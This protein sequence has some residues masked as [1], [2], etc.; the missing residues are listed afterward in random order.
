MNNRELAD[1]YFSQQD[2]DS[3]LAAYRAGMDAGERLYR[4]GLST[5]SKATEVAENAHLY[6]HAAFAAARLG[7]AAEALLILER[8]KTRLLTEA[9]RLRVPRPKDVP[10]EV[11]TAF[12]Q[13][14]A[15]VRVVQSRD[16]AMPGEGRDPVQAYATR[17]QNAQSASAALDAAVERVRAHAPNFLRAIDWPTLQA[18]LPDEHTVLL[19]FCMTDQR[20][21]GFVL[22]HASGEPVRVVDVPN[23]TQADLNSLL[24]EEDTDGN[25]NGGWLWDY[26]SPDRSRWHR[27]AEYVLAQVGQRLVAPVVAALPTGI[28][29]LILLPAGGLFLLPL[30]AVSL[31]NGDSDRLCDRYQISYAPSA[32]V[33]ADSRTKAMRASGQALY[34]VINPEVDP[35]LVFTPVEGT[36]I[37]GLFTNLQVHEG[38]AGTKQAVVAGLNGKAFLHFSCH[39]SYNWIDPLESGLALA[40]GRLT[41]AEL[42]SGTVDLSAARLVTLSACETGIIDVLE[43]RAEEYVGLP[44][45]FMLAGVPCVVSSLWS[46]PDIS[47]ALLMGR[48]YRNH[49]KGGMNFPAAL[50]EAQAW[51][52]RLEA[53]EVAEYAE[54]CYRQSKSVQKAKLLEEHALRYRKW[55]ET[56]PSAKP[57]A[58]PYYWAAFTV[59]GM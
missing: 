13:A 58:H 51:V 50:Q 56:D 45:G 37:A 35:R 7:N 10:D 9:L 20:S 49:L 31:S 33:L 6:R 4:A 19:A 1:I 46:V 54:T 57:F 59:N 55:A 21:L 22:S 25:P 52:R 3:A 14:G 26:V 17:I 40:D 32:E 53:K 42:Q 43:G 29:K 30:H 36:A 2:W 39:G 23:F 41:L 27:T 48:F 8:G 28:R 38:G 16:T 12:E 18:L 47:T 15:A 11:W 24:I 5:E 34:A 44:A